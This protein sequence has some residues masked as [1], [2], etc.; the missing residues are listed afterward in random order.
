[1]SN[2]NGKILEFFAKIP[3]LEAD[4]S[5]WVI[6]KDRFMFAA[7]AASLIDHID[8]TGKVPSPP[9]TR[10]TDSGALTEIQQGALDE[11]AAEL[12][13]WR[14]GEAIVRQAIASTI[15]DSLFLEVRKR[16][17]AKEMWDAVRDQREKKS[18]MVT[19]DLRRKL[20]AEKCPESGD[21][22]AHLYKLQA[23]REDLASMGGSIND[24][25]FTSIILGSIP[26]SY[27]TYIAAITA[28]S[29]LLNQ[30]LSPTNLIDAIRDEADRRT[31][32][33]PKSKKDEHDSAFV[34][35]Q[36]SDRGKK[37]GEGSKKAI[38]GKCYNCK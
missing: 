3:K 28:T 4:G 21:I 32:K 36:C 9:V 25:D 31:I 7:A 35:N 14:S 27:D 8:G 6:F 30:T 20:Q 17:S 16:E 18:R 26:L 22:R 33:N 24:E 5:N 29:S 10:T 34:A 13:R 15:S 2:T 1:M 11:Y 38:K 37:G 19:V 12:S 23:M